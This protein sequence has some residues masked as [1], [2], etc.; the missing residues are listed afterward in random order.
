MLFVRPPDFGWLAL[1]GFLLMCACPCKKTKTETRYYSL[2]SDCTWKD[3]SCV[4]SDT[5]KK[6]ADG[7]LTVFECR[8]PEGC[9]TYDSVTYCD[10]SMARV[11][12]RCI[13]PRKD[14][15]ITCSDDER[16]VLACVNDTWVKSKDCRRCV[17]KV[18][19]RDGLTLPIHSIECE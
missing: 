7:K 1:A 2:A 9:K 16:A 17:T 19:P 18:T 14:Q 3:E 13:T 5:A 11:G 12:D 6:C 4:D 15:L 8:G 10:G